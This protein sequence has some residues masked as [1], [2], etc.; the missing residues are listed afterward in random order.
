MYSIIGTFD[1]VFD[2][3]DITGEKEIEN[4]LS[5]DQVVNSVRKNMIITEKK[6]RKEDPEV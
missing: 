6:F 5:E 2:A 1:L 3:T 4:S